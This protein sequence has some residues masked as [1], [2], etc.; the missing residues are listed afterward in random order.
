MAFMTNDPRIGQQDPKQPGNGAAVG[1]HVATN[2]D[3]NVRAA[4][5][6]PTKPYAVGDEQVN[7]YNAKYGR[8]SPD[9]SLPDVRVPGVDVNPAQY[10]YSRDNPRRVEIP[11]RAKRSNAPPSKGTFG[12]PMP[13]ARNKRRKSSKASKRDKCTRT[14]RPA[15]RR[16]S[17]KRNSNKAWIAALPDSLPWQTR[18]MGAPRNAPEPCGTPN[19]RAKIRWPASAL[20]APRSV[21]KRRPRPAKGCLARTKTL[22]IRWPAFGARIKAKPGST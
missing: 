20:K 5:L 22:R 16:A 10:Q 9:W 8:T 7:R 14:P 15:T 2:A 21:P 11:K 19:C 6:V 13:C 1:G 17:P 18:P 4:P 3:P 12:K